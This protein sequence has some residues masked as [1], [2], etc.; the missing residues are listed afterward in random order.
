MLTSLRREWLHGP[1][2]SVDSLKMY[3]PWAVSLRMCLWMATL[4][5]SSF[6]DWRFDCGTAD[7]FAFEMLSR[8]WKQKLS[9]GSNNLQTSDSLTRVSFSK[10]T[11]PASSRHFAGCSE[12]RR[13]QRSNSSIS[14]WCYL[15]QVMLHANELVRLDATSGLLTTMSWFLVRTYILCFL[16]KASKCLPSPVY[17]TAQPVLWQNDRMTG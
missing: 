3:C 14:S 15:P 6:S 2:L 13:R 4:G 16:G 7:T 17:R 11:T 8:Q 9:N 1:Q 5:R 12:L 10:Q